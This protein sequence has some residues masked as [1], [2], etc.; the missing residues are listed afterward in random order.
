MRPATLGDIPRPYELNPHSHNTTNPHCYQDP[1]S[2]TAD[3]DGK[4]LVAC[5]CGGFFEKVPVERV[6]FEAPLCSQH[7]HIRADS[8]SPTKRKYKARKPRLNLK[9]AA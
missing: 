2:Y 3:D 9:K 5:P 7:G 8:G 1:S 6:G 4:V